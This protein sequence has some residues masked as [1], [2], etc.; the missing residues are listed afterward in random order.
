ME[1]LNICTLIAGIGLLAF[2]MWAAVISAIEKEKKAAFSF[3]YT[4]VIVS[5][6]VILLFFIP[7]PFRDVVEYILF[8]LLFIVL[9]IFIIPVKPKNISDVTPV[10]GYDERNTMFSRIRLHAGDKKYNDY[11]SQHPENKIVDDKIKT[12]PGLLAPGTINYDP[13]YFASADASFYTVEALKPLVDGP[14]AKKTQETDIEELT[15]YIKKWAKKLGA[16]HVGIT[17]VKDYHL[18]SHRGRGAKYGHEVANNHKYAIA[19]T[20]EMDVDSV[21]AAPQAPIVKESAQQYLNA[22]VIAIQLAQFIRNLGYESRA[23]IDGDYEV[24]CPL[25]A[26]DAGLGEIGRMG[27]LMTPSHGPRV[28]IAVVTCNVPLITDK[29]N[30][31]PSVIDFCEKCKKCA[32]VCPSKAISDKPREIIG[33]VERWQINQEKCFDLWTKFGTDCGRCMSVCPY[34]HPNN[35]LHN[36][37]RFGI[38]NSTIFSSMALWLDNIYYG[39]KP[40]I[41]KY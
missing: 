36:I 3:F 40:K 16:L 31:D 6:P 9:L 14:V 35:L 21:K 25:V 39:R 32:E 17:E 33:G 23:H 20:V 26:R 12:N 7:F 37:I 41:R 19:F 34:S 24:I 30:F 10:S 11:Y 15:K 38:R 18:Y 13:L 27:L 4:G 29:R 22:G 8:G 1:L 5:L 28:R 2:F